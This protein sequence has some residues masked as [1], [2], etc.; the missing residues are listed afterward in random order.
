MLERGG[1]VSIFIRLFRDTYMMLGKLKTRF[2]QFKYIG[3]ATSYS[4]FRREEVG[5][6]QKK[7][8]QGLEEGIEDLG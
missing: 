8:G 6:G 4:L 5:V 3:V 1:I 7:V 2:P